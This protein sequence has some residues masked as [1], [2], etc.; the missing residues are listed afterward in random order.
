MTTDHLSRRLRQTLACLLDGD[1]EKRAAQ[2]LGISRS[3]LHQYVTMLYRH[4]GVTSVRRRIADIVGDS[5]AA[6]SRRKC[7]RLPTCPLLFEV[8][9]RSNKDTAPPWRLVSPPSKPLTGPASL[10]RSVCA[11]GLMSFPL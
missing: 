1:T 7:G 8:W 11:P 10:Q 5:S 2:R 9:P 4:F 3:T 6:N